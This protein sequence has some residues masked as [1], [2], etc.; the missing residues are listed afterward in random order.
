MNEIE[1]D[2]L[3]RVRRHVYEMRDT[4]KKY[5]N[6]SSDIYKGYD[7]ACKEMIQFVKP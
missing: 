3:R 5:Y 6:K 1:E 4:T 2:T 7:M